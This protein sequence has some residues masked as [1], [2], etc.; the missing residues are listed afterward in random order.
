MLFLQELNSILKVADSLQIRGLTTNVQVPPVND[1]LL[2]MT[3]NVKVYIL[4]F[5]IYYPMLTNCMA[6]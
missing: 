2:M 4:S 5:Y 3:E 1:D 6:T